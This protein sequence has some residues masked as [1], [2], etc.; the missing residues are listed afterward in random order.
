LLENAYSTN[1]TDYRLFAAL[2]SGILARPVRVLL[3]LS[4][5][6][7]AA[8]L[9]AGLLSG[10]LILLTGILVRISHRYLP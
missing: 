1:L 4:G 5:L 2:L 6:L 7:P 9:L 10:V 3:L 8:L